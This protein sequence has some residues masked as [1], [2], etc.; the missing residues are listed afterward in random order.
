MKQSIID[1]YKCAYENKKQSCNKRAI[2]FKFTLP[3][4]AALMEG[5]KN[6]TCAYSGEAFTL[7]DT[8]STNYPELDRIDPVGAYSKENCVFCCRKVH[9]WKTDYIEKGKSL[10]NAND[11]VIQI[12]HRINKIL[13]NKSGMESMMRPY[14]GIYKQLANQTKETKEQERK[15]AIKSQ[16]INIQRERIIAE[17]YNNFLEEVLQAGGEPLITFAQ[18][19]RKINNKTCGLTGEVLPVDLKK[20]SLYIKNKSCEIDN[21][22]IVCTTEEL[23]KAL[24]VLQGTC[25]FTTKMMKKLGKGLIK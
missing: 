7:G 25:G 4:Y 8:S 18:Y 19:K 9:K 16:L 20:R 14:Q 15:K 12:T 21:R 23:S 24:D 1:R 17:M 22:N 6:L 5:R 3:E 13:S 2:D 11:R 10:K